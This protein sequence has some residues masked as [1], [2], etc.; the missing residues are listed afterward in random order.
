MISDIVCEA[1]QVMTGKHQ[2]S[3]KYNQAKCMKLWQNEKQHLKVIWKVLLSVDLLGFCGGEHFFFQFYDLIPF[4]NISHNINFFSFSAAG[5]ANGKQSEGKYFIKES[6][7][8]VNRWH[9]HYQVIGGSVGIAWVGD[10]TQLPLGDIHKLL[11]AS[12]DEDAP[13]FQPFGGKRAGRPWSLSLQSGHLGEVWLAMAD[14]DA[15]LHRVMNQC[16]CSE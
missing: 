13:M 2:P 12:W 16:G 3:V 15:S 11:D 10:P 7:F 1:C 9:S 14:I 8:N 6:E 5:E 4:I